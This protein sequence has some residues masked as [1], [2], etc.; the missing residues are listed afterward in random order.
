MGPKFL[1]SGVD[2]SYMGR[3]KKDFINALG[4]AIDNLEPAEMS[5]ALIPTNPLTP[6]EDKRKPIV[7]DDIKSN[8]I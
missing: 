1:K 8:F 6:I 4:M 5:L 3:L 7:I 2:E